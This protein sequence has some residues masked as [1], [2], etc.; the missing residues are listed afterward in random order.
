MVGANPYNSATH[1]FQWLEWE[2]S[3]GMPDDHVLAWANERA[4]VAQIRADAL[5]QAHRSAAKERRERLKAWRAGVAQIMAEVRRREIERNG[6][7]RFR[8][9]A[10]SAPANPLNGMRLWA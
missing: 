8:V 4:R 7:P 5:A 1:P 9:E 6:K 3:Y 2:R 10:I